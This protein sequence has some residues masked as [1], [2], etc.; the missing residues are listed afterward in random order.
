MFDETLTSLT[1]NTNSYLTSRNT[2]NYSEDIVTFSLTGGI[3]INKV[4]IYPYVSAAYNFSGILMANSGS[5]LAQVGQFDKG[6]ATTS[7]T[8]IV[9]NS[10]S[11]TELRLRGNLLV[12]TYG[13][14]GYSINEL[15]IIPPSS[16]FTT[17][18][19]ST[20]TSPS[21]IL[22]ETDEDLSSAGSSVSYQISFDNFVTS[23]SITPKTLFTSIP[24][25]A[26]SFRVRFTL[27]NGAGLKAYALGWS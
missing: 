4:I 27:N 9:L 24:S 6:S 17:S 16:Y 23:S 22:L 3:Q 15:K 5:G 18:A 11:V 12:S 8:T 20:T 1:T 21:R 13:S 26:T 25:G 2:A 10:N 7:N 14:A 19:I